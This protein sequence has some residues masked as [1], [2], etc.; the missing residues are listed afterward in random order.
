MGVFQD[1]KSGAEF[2]EAVAAWNVNYTVA[3]LKKQSEVVEQKIISQTKNVPE[4]RCL[5]QTT[6]SWS[7][8]FF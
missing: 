3:D 2:K 1:D 6:L 5:S 4:E 8:G 7:P